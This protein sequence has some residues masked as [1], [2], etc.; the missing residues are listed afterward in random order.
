MPVATLI[1]LDGSKAADSMQKSS[2]LSITKR[3]T[4]FFFFFLPD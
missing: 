2:S 4:F 3:L 1:R